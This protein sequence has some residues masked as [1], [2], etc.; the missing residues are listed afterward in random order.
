RAPCARA[1]ARAGLLALM[2]ELAGG[3]PIRARLVLSYAQLWNLAPRSAPPPPPPSPPAP[4]KAASGVVRWIVGE[5]PSHVTAPEQ[6][7]GEAGPYRG[8]PTAAP[9]SAPARANAPTLRDRVE[10]LGAQF[11]ALRAPVELALIAK[12][13]VV[14]RRLVAVR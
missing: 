2:R 12:R 11:A 5:L 1:G 9:A 13:A 4:P 3:Q 6:P 8:G 14:D 7:P 10:R